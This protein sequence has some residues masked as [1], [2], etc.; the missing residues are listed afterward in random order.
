MPPIP[1]HNLVI[2]VIFVIIVAVIIAIIVIIVTV[3][4]VVI[5]RSR[6][7][8]CKLLFLVWFHKKGM[9]GFLF[10]YQKNA[11]VL[12]FWTS[13]DHQTEGGWPE[14]EAFYFLL[15]WSGT[16]FQGPQGPQGPHH[17]VGLLLRHPIIMGCLN[18]KPTQTKADLE[19][20][21]VHVPG[22]NFND[23]QN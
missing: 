6:T 12:F 17:W 15:V 2:N 20:L 23:W 16:Q 22:Q 13:T 8:T 18:R 9:I 21:E 1:C 10:E 14:G 3:M 4:S 7:S 11:K 5:K 19:D